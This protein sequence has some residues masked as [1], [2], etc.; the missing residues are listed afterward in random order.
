MKTLEIGVNEAVESFN[1]F[2]IEESAKLV[3]YQPWLQ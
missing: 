3:G 2:N 1:M